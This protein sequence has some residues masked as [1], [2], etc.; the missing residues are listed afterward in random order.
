MAGNMSSVIEVNESDFDATVLRS[1]TPVIVDFWAPWCAPCRAIAPILD[2]VASVLDGLVTVA[3]VNVDDN[4]KIAA[5]YGVQSIPTLLFFHRG[6]AV[7]RLV[8]LVPEATI[9]S[10][11]QSLT[12]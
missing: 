12:N 3:K 4:P 10:K 1:E 9:V 5:K 7:E 8:G 11:A 2:R 6:E